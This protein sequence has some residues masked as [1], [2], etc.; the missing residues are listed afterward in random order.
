MI[1]IKKTYR[2]SV[3]NHAGEVFK[4]TTTEEGAAVRMWN[5]VNGAAH[6]LYAVMFENGRII[7]VYQ[8]AVKVDG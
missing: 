3:V 2:V 7:R 4:R 8:K 6:V 5:D 1:G